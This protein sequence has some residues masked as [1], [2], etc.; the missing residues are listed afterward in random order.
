M[1]TFREGLGLF[2]LSFKEVWIAD[3]TYFFFNLLMLIAIP[4]QMNASIY[5]APR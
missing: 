4:F 3:K 2:A 5:L 1:K